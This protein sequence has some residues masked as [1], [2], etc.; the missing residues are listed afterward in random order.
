MMN[1]KVEIFSA[2]TQFEL[3]ELISAFLEGANIYL[4]DIKFSTVSHEQMIH[5]SA[6]VIYSHI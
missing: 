4:H 1:A 3:K 2:D 5:H 6:M